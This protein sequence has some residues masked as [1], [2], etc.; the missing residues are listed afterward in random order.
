MAAYLD[1]LAD[2][3]K[4]LGDIGH[5]LENYIDDDDDRR[6][7]AEVFD[8]ELDFDDASAFL[9]GRDV[10]AVVQETERDVVDAFIARVRSGGDHVATQARML[11]LGPRGWKSDPQLLVSRLAAFELGLR[12]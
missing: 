1:R 12:S 3:A 4:D 8:R 5:V 6:Y 7:S 9:L 11:K 2:R 10:G